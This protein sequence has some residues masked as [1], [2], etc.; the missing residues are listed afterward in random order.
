MGT[1]VRTFLAVWIAI[2]ALAP[3]AA[4]ADTQ[5]ITTTSDVGNEVHWDISNCSNYWNLGGGAYTDTWSMGYPIPAWGHSYAVIKEKDK[6]RYAMHAAAYPTAGT[7]GGGNYTTNYLKVYAYEDWD[8]YDVG[9][10]IQWMPPGTTPRVQA[11]GEFISGPDIFKIVFDGYDANGRIIR[12]FLI[13][14]SVFNMPSHQTYEYW[15]WPGGGGSF[16]GG[17]GGDGWPPWPGDD[18]D[19]G[20][21]DW[22]DWDGGTGGSPGSGPGFCSINGLPVWHVNPANSN[23]VVRDS[24]FSYRSLGP[25]IEVL[26]TYNAFQIPGVSP[27]GMFGLRWRLKYEWSFGEMGVAVGDGDA[28]LSTVVPN[29]VY[30]VD[31]E[32]IRYEF[33]NQGASSGDRPFSLTSPEGKRVSLYLNAALD[34]WV[35]HNTDEHLTY[36]FGAYT[37]NWAPYLARL[38]SITDSSGNAVTLDYYEDEY[39]HAHEFFRIAR[40]TDAVGRITSFTLSSNNP[41]GWPLCS[42]MTT[43][44]G[45]SCTYEYD[46]NANL[47]RIVDMLGTEINHVYSGATQDFPMTQI[48]VGPKVETFT[49]DTSVTGSPRITSVTDA[50][51]RTV[52]HFTDDAGVSSIIA[53]NGDITTYTSN[54]DGLITQVLQ[55]QGRDMQR[56]VRTRSPDR[57]Q[58]DRRRRNDPRLRRLG[59]PDPDHRPHRRHHQLDLRRQRPPGLAQ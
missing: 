49:Y 46:A 5:T 29:K 37:A 36:H 58:P 43:P 23:L 33:Q 35:L 9:W 39:P 8:V 54:S 41:S 3:R 42:R 7:A 50:E 15:G 21:P 51:G 53:P 16:G 26:R 30:F 59:Q 25:D 20:D 34:Q 4:R 11:T 56:P 55:L 1:I 13:T 17:G 12:R 57:R 38:E 44:D 52:T 40:I 14:V 31:G 45:R 22:P 10:D 48:Q 27:I 2:L 6:S 18:G 19:P 28:D 32:G 47:T 24:D